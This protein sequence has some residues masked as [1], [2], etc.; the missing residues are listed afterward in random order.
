M[1][2][3][4]GSKPVPL[5]LDDI[6]ITGKES[7]LDR[8]AKFARRWL[9]SKGLMVQEERKNPVDV[10]LESFFQNCKD[11]QKPKADIEIG[12]ADSIAVML[13]NQ[14]MDENRRVY[15]SEIEKMGTPGAAPVKKG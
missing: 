7:F 1:V 15:F 5:M 13:A 14:A 3:A 9:F 12:L 4:G 2:S 8:E 11:L 6:N 10:E